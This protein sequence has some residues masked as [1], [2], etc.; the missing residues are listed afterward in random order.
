MVIHN[1]NVFCA[2]VRP[3]ETY[4]ELIIDPDAV[5]AGT[6]TLQDFKPIA[7]GHTKVVQSSSDL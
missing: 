4:A 7:W 2:S 6:I 3:A 5:L 1:L